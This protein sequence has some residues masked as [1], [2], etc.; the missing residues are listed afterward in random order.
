LKCIDGPVGSGPLSC[1]QTS[2]NGPADSLA[3]GWILDGRSDPLGLLEL[4]CGRLW[5]ALVTKVFQLLA[6]L[7]KRADGEA[8]GGGTIRAETLPQ[9]GQH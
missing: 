7:W 5:H 2:R 9:A 6:E 1:C 8:D 4:P 3:E